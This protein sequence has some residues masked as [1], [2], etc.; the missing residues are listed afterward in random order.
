[1]TDDSKRLG[2]SMAAVRAVMLNPAELSGPKAPEAPLDRAQHLRGGEF[3]LWSAREDARLLLTPLF[4]LVL[5]DPVLAA[6]RRAIDD[7]TAA[8][9]RRAEAALRRPV[10]DM[11]RTACL[12]VADLLPFHQWH[13]GSKEAAARCAADALESACGWVDMGLISEGFLAFRAACLYACDAQEDAYVDHYVGGPVYARLA[14]Y[15]FRAESW[16]R[17]WTVIAGAERMLDDEDA[18]LRGGA[19]Q[20]ADTSDLASLDDILAEAQAAQR[21]RAEAD[22]RAAASK[23]PRT[24]VVFPKLGHLPKPSASQQDRGDSPRALVEAYAEKPLPLVAAPDPHAFSAALLARFPWA[25]EV[26]EAYAGDLVGAPFAGFRPR[27]LVS[28]PGFGKTAFARELLE[29]AGLDVT[30]Y[31]AAGQMDGGAFA[32]TSRQWGSWRMSTSAQAIL[33]AQK[34]SV[35]IVVDEVEK[36]GT[37]RRW[38]RLDETILPFLEHTARSIHDPALEAPVDLSAVSYVLTANSLGGIVGPLRD[39]VPALHWPAPREQDLPIVAAAILGDLRRERGLDATWCPD[40][41]PEDLDMIPWKGGSMR[42]LRRMV[43][44][45][46]ASRD[47]FTARH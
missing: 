41:S 30:L 6:V 3:V 40:L 28:G 34:A 39:R 23:A 11:S 2:A 8:T 31:S 26:I 10:P 36:A 1:M 21:A 14:A 17:A 25:P 24:L 22:K 46:L 15:D 35:G 7:T 13:M 16:L 32:G 43:E 4:D 20:Q 12:E 18:I 33:R 42:P 37:S 9:L 38:G 45:V 19:G 44:T 5:P 27:I 29:A 47:R